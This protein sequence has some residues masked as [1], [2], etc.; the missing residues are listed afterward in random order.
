VVSRRP[1]TAGRGSAAVAVSAE[2]AVPLPQLPIA[3]AAAGRRV[4]RAVAFGVFMAL[5]AALWET[6][7]A[8]LSW[9]LTR[10]PAFHN[11]TV[12]HLLLG[13]TLHGGQFTFALRTAL[14]M[15]LLGALGFVCSYRASASARPVAALNNGAC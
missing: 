8:L 14:V 2:T 4:S 15:L 9:L 3:R 6:I 1:S 11:P 13:G 12:S 10:R 7:P 5:C